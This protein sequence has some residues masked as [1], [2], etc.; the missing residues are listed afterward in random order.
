MRKKQNFS[1]YRTFEETSE[2]GFKTDPIVPDGS[3][4]IEK[5]DFDLSPP[6]KQP[7]GSLFLLCAGKAL[8]VRHVLQVKPSFI[9]MAR[10]LEANNLTS[11][12]DAQNVTVFLPTSEGFFQFDRA[13]YGIG[14]RDAEKWRELFAYG[15]LNQPVRVGELPESGRM[16]SR[17]NSALRLYVNTFHTRAGKVITINGAT[18][19]E[20]DIRTDNGI[21]HIVDRVIAPVGSSLTIAKYIEYPELPNLEFSSILLAAVVVPSLSKQTDNSSSMHTSF[22]PNDSYLFPMPN[23]GKD[24]L[25]NN[26]TLLIETYRAHI[27]ENEALFLPASVDYLPPK[28]ALFGNL[29]FY[30]RDDGK[31]YVMNGGIHARVIR[32]NIPTVNGVIHVID[33]LLRYVYQNAL[34]SIGVMRDTRLFSQLLTSL[35]ESRQFVVRNLTVTVFVP[36]DWAF[37]KVPL[38]WQQRLTEGHG[39]DQTVFSHVIA[40]SVVDSSLWKD[41]QTLTMMNN[42]TVTI[43]EMAGE[44]YL[45]TSD[46]RVRSR[47]EVMDIGVINGAVHL[48]KNM[49]YSDQFTVWDAVSDMPQL[50]SIHDFLNSH[51]QEMRA[52]LNMST[53]PENTV[54]L[55]SN[56][57]MARALDYLNI[58]VAVDSGMLLKA[59]QGHVIS[60]RHSSSSFV[61]ETTYITLAQ[62][63]KNITIRK[64]ESSS[65]ITITGGHVTS[66]VL[67]K[68]IYCSNGVLHILDDL[69]H[70]PTRTVG[71]EIRLRPELRYM[72]VLLQTL[73]D[74]QYD[75]DDRRHNYTVFVANND[76]FS[77]LPWNT[78]SS[79]MV[80]T[81]W[82]TEVLRAHVVPGEMRQLEEIP[83]K[84]ALTA[85]F[86]V[87]YLVKRKNKVYVINNNMAAEVLTR[88]IPAI[89]GWVHV[90]DRILTVPYRRLADVLASGQDDVSLFHQI[91]TAV[92]EYV[93]TVMKPTRNVTLFIP[94]TR[95]IMSLEA[96][97]L[98]WIKNHPEILRRL[99]YG[100][101]LPNVRLD[102]VFLREFPDQDYRSRSAYNISFTITRDNGETFLDAGFDLQPLDVVSRAIGCMDGIIYVIDGFLNYSPFSLL[103]RLKREPELS[104]S[105]RQMTRLVTPSELHLLDNQDLS[106]TFFMPGDYALD[107]ITSSNLKE[108]HSLPALQKQ[109]IFWRHAVNG[110][111]LYYEDLQNVDTV[112]DLLPQGVTLD[113]YNDNVY[114][115]YKTISSMVKQYN[116]IASNGVIHVLTKFL[117]DFRSVKDPSDPT[118]APPI[119]SSTNVPG[120]PSTIDR[121]LSHSIN[122]IEPHSANLIEPHTTNL[123]ES[124]S[125]N[126]IEPHSTNL[127]ESHSANL[128]E[129]HTTNLIESHSANLIEPHSTNL[130]ESQSTKLIELHSANFIESQSTNLIESHYTNLIESHSANLIEIRVT[131]KLELKL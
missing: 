44:F 17:L 30:Y 78:V 52:M 91:L 119:T 120:T 15:S 50:R 77:A 18:I 7:Q 101:V 56:E 79:L 41:G 48:I 112:K 67:V 27:I 95:Y 58:L 92:P 124:H 72:Q 22:S 29:K 55:P 12:F 93:K 127:I 70:I 23:H 85:K 43:R 68:D 106:F 128:I 20:P 117:Y 47:V 69:L 88:D 83:A 107:Y 3:V 40:G 109:K 121:N 59:L 105:V 57:V 25:F 111:I 64:A 129:P 130:I 76:A 99:M 113:H 89:N 96:Q 73:A 118:A 49:L 4:C 71:H 66:K 34:E 61:G 110:T 11:L 114:V 98:E 97:Q 123:I 37:S 35:P 16:I 46:Q 21:L 62:N 122:L 24:P 39:T 8:S 126:L 75:L 2:R 100:H 36:T 125:A 53:N 26:N 115:R 5:E 1:N 60:G 9:M 108:M 94:S 74:P 81:N 13:Y 80:N 31:L 104:S 32:P 51:F 33:N 65:E 42:K 19:L 87:V 103:E 131:F 86:N 82:T 102:D 38:Y 45:E 90:I 63:G 116:L 6:H 14:E 54:F 84:V 10:V 28:K